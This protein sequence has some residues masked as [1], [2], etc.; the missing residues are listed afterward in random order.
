MHMRKMPRICVP[1]Q[2][3]QFVYITSLEEAQE[4]LE[5]ILTTEAIVLDNGRSARFCSGLW[6]KLRFCWEAHSEFCTYTLISEG[7]SEGLFDVS[8]F[9]PQ[10]TM[11][12]DLPG[13][14]FRSTI[15]NLVPPGGTARSECFETHFAEEDLVI[16]E[17]KSG[18]ARVL[19]DFRL[20][21]DGFG[22]M[23]VEDR[24]LEGMEPAD[25][26]QRLQ[27]L[28][29]YRKMALLGLPVAKEQSTDIDDLEQQLAVIATDQVRGTVPI[30]DLMQKLSEISSRLSVIASTTRYRM[31]ATQAYA[32]IVQDRLERLAA[33]SEPGH[34][35]LDEFT[36]RRFLPAIRTCE[37]FRR[38]LEELSDHTSAVSDLLRTRIDTE[39]ARR[40]QELLA[41][42]NRR[43]E[44]QL[45]LQQ[46]VEGLSLVAITYYALGVWKYL[47][48]AMGLRAESELGHVITLLLVFVIPALTWLILHR[49]RV[50]S[51]KHEA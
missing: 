44:L 42:M 23:L 25:L 7:E 11:I 18:R 45:R 22:H 39:L 35:S 30:E 26:V 17:V 28:G 21:D 33:S 49:I 16:S 6:G 36:E 5:A 15:I 13:A 46:T 24:G 40:N 37:A 47:A 8:S 48:D 38:R 32:A 10:C 4:G 2:I 34:L 50:R 1:S 31:S 3:M 43:T 12:S 20:H 29:N 19:C 9:D 51:L 27:D 41:S 14:I